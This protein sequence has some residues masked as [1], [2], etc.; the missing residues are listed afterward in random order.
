ME[1]L[2]ALALSTL[3]LLL[4]AQLWTGVE[5]RSA[6]ITDR[7]VWQLQARVAGI[8]LKHDLRS[9]CA[10]GGG[11]AGVPSL[12]LEADGGRLVML[13]R[14]GSPA[15]VELVGKYTDI[16]QIG[17]RN[18]QNYLLLEEVGKRLRGLMSWIDAKDVS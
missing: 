17:A 16:F 9:A 6:D 11:S 4:L 12:L 10:V 5:K 8:R 1:V 3:L 2:V 18:S 7:L 13:A 14:T 15:D